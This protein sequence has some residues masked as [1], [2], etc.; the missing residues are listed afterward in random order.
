MAKKSS[1]NTICDNRRA[2]FDYELLDEFEAGIVLEG[3]EVKSLRNNKAQISGSYVKFLNYELFLIGAQIIPSQSINTHKEAKYDRN[4]KLLLHKKEID[5]IRGAL[6]KKSLSC[7]PLKLKWK[8]HMVKCIIA[9][10]RG[11]K[12]HDKR[13]SIKDRELKR[14]AERALKM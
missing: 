10:A 14:S 1:P 4:R 3:W 13:A 5:K 12:I 7:V 8:K 9:T 2:Y 6:E 11:K